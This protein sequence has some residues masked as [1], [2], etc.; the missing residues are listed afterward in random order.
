[1]EKKR[2]AKIETAV[3]GLR[4]DMI[5]T[6]AELVRIPSVVG[7]EGPA[8]EFMQRQYEDLG[9]DMETFEADKN[10]VGQHS[11][12]VESGLSFDGRPNVIGL[13]KGDAQKK[14]M[15]LNGHVDVVSPEPVD[16]WQHD[17]WGAEIEENR[18]YGRGAVDMKAGVIANLFAL[19]ALIKAGIDPGGDVMLQSVVEE[20][21]GGG[22]GTLA[23]LMEGY[24]ADG[25]IIT[26][27]FMVPVISHT[28]ILYFR[29]KINGLTAHA[30]HA[31]LGVNAIGKMMKVYEAMVD[32]DLHRAATIE[33]PLYHKVEGRSCHLNIGTLKA[34]DW[35][36][37]VAGF[38]EMACRISFIPGESMAEIKT[39]VEQVIEDVARV[40]DWLEAHPPEV[41][42]FGW[43]TE[44]WY[45]DPDD[46]FIQTVLPCFE[47]ACG[48]KLEIAGATAGLD[49]RFSPYFGFPSICFG[50][51]G[52]DYH[53]FDEY[54]ELDS[55]VL[56]TKA[57][58]LATLEWC[59][60][61]KKRKES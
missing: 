20:E 49:N 39:T 14:S 12:Y 23:C 2:K 59:S 5:H 29:V 44:P 10:K 9:L 26:E 28:G 43:Q 53:S 18:L 11:A 57:V 40:D 35:V 46:P 48:Q 19:K 17:P 4:D 24:T 55:L 3:D 7:N 34:G 61:D 56:A 52:N 47:A 37:T 45:Q 6:L 27:P 21:A 8:Q 22:G 50:P 30:G 36:S 32:L 31:H 1:M 41:E 25:M 51:D 33:F 38:A 13:L 54:V 16:Q 60:Q 15:I 42:W 58:G